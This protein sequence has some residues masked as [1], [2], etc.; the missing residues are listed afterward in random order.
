MAS[1]TGSPTLGKRRVLDLRQVAQCGQIF[2]CKVPNASPE[3]RSIYS[4]AIKHQFYAP[5]TSFHLTGGLN[6]LTRSEVHGCSHF[7]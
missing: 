2:L 3:T 6:R 7:T 1:F 4:T 5:F